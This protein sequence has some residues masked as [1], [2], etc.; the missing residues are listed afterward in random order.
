MI[1]SLS[2]GHRP[3]VVEGTIVLYKT[4]KCQLLASWSKLL[5]V[6]AEYTQN[7]RYVRLLVWSLETILKRIGLILLSY[8]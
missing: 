4:P 3:L 1:C 2:H 8:F 5:L 7:P 6:L